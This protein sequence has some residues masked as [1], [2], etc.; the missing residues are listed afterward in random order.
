MLEDFLVANNENDQTS[1]TVTVPERTT[2]LFVVA[3]DNFYQ[4]NSA[5]TLRIELA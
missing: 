4:D 1:T 5:F 3:V 2:H